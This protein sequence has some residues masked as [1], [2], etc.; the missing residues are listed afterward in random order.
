[1]NAL[2]VRR[3]HGIAIDEVAVR[4][5]LR[6]ATIRRDDEEVR[7]SIV[8]EPLPVV[9]VLERGDD[10]RRAG[11]LLLLLTI[12]LLP[13]ANTRDHA[14]TGAVG[15]PGGVSD[16]GFQ[17]GES[18]GLSAVHTNHVELPLLLRLAF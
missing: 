15:R 6:R 12:G 10:A 8:G 7:A 5:L 11:L 2:P 9:L 4:D 18:N 16:A 17:V 3:P 13:A 1:V 14:E